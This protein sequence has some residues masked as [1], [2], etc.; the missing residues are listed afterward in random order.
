MKIT[1]QE[2]FLRGKGSF[3][4]FN[5]NSFAF[6]SVGKTFTV[7]GRSLS[8]VLPGMHIRVPLSPLQGPGDGGKA[9]MIVLIV[10]T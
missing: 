10:L 7:P 3:G 6:N 1:P 5:I 4:Y 9:L 8:R 2:T